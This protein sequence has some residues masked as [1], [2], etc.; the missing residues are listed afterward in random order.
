MDTEDVMDHVRAAD[1]IIMGTTTQ[2]AGPYR[3][4]DFAFVAF[5]KTILGIQPRT[6]HDEYAFD[7][8]VE[9]SFKG[10]VDGT[11]RA[12]TPV[13]ES[14]CG[15][16]F[17]VGKRY[18]V[19]ASTRDERRT[20]SLCSGTSAFEARHPEFPQLLREV[21]HVPPNSAL[22]R[23]GTHKVLGRGRPSHIS[24]HGRWRARVLKRRRAAAELDS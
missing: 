10:N 22:Q 11:L 8:N 1:V 15:V 17:V 6:D 12:Y 24:S 7:F 14:A 9:E 18:F 13:A 2:R 23:S 20:V 19:F 16:E 3:R 21:T 4:R 5:L